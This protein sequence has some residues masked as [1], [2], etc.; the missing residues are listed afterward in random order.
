MNTNTNHDQEIDLNLILNKIQQSTNY[1][2]LL[3][4]NFLLFIRKNSLLLFFLIASGIS[5]GYYIDQNNKPYYSEIIVSPNFESTEYLYSKID[6][7][8]TKIKEGDVKF[9]KSIGIKNP[10]IIT[11]IKI[12]PIIDIYSLINHN[13]Q[14][15][16]SAQNTQNFEMMKLL[17]EDSDI[18]KVINDEV[19]SKNYPLHA[20]KIRTADKI[21]DKDITEPI[22]RYLN[23]NTFYAAIQ[24]IVLKNTEIKIKKNQ[25]IINQIDALLNK[26]S[27]SSSNESK[28][29][30][31]VYYN[32][33]T[34]LND[35]IISKNKLLEEISAQD[36]NRI[37]YSKIIK[38]TAL[39]LNNIDHKGINGKMKLILPLL[40]FLIFIM[41]T[42]LKVFYE[43]QKKKII[44]P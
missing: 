22:L 9:L 44:N 15:A 17:A 41:V 7:L 20:I 10:N 30:K 38:Q 6:L 32:E 43:T 39:I 34:Q 14:I 28:N 19:T 37:I 23:N 31:L 8:S 1:F 26:F 12:S 4:F 3:I 5:L 40:L 13:T 24:K 21:N 25:E 2:T 11:S 35:I 42:V 16:T 33:N 36:M 27:S 18:N 29:E